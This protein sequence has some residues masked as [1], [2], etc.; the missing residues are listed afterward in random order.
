MKNKKLTITLL[1]ILSLA[2]IVL[3]GVANYYGYRDDLWWLS[4]AAWIAGAFCCLVKCRKAM[5]AGLNYLRNEPDMEEAAAGV[6]A[7]AILAGLIAWGFLNQ[8]T[9]G[10]AQIWGAQC[11]AA[12]ELPLI[13]YLIR[14]VINSAA[15]CVILT[16]AYM[17]VGVFAVPLAAAA[18][19][20]I[21]FGGKKRLANSADLA[22][23]H[24]MASA[25]PFV[26]L[27]QFCGMADYI[28]LIGLGDMLR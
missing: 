6:V 1:C 16:I 21:L 18:I 7:V 19:A 10:E 26:L 22:T 15:A 27:S 23:S 12:L 24:M 2:T 13:T 17:I 4:F 20:H 9:R 8:E 3:L 28:A 5:V 14:Y 25:L 11:E